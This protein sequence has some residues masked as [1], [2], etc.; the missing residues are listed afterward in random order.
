MSM[1]R[2]QSILERMAVWLAVKDARLKST[3]NSFDEIELEASEL[4]LN[5]YD[6]YMER[7]ARLWGRMQ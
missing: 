2:E 4:F 7:A 1:K 6:W 3:A 5:Q